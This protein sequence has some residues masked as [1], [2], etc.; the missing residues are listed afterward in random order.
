[1]VLSFWLQ[2]L[3]RCCSSERPEPRDCRC[4]L[5]GMAKH[6]SGRAVPLTPSRDPAVAV[7]IPAK[8]LAMILPCLMLPFLGLLIATHWDLSKARTE[9]KV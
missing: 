8:G 9:Q 4:S 1:M 6:C 2:S 7:F 5:K 3:W